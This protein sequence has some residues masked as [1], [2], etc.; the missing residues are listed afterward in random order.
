VPFAYGH[1][2][3]HD[4]HSVARQGE[5][6]V[7]PFVDLPVTVQALA[8]VVIVGVEALVLYL[9]YG[10]LEELFGSRIIQAVGNS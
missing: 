1:L 7:I 9:G 3:N 8:I 4:Q 6:R 5:L 10:Y 2:H